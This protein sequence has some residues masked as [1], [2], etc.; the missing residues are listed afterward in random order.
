MSLFKEKIEKGC[1]RTL[2]SKRRA[3]VHKWMK[4]QM[5]KCLR[6]QAKDVSEE[7]LSPK[8]RNIGWEF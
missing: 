4:R 5:N 7:S 6:I 2:F 1:I 3:G 8:K